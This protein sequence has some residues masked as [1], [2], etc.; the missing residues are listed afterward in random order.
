MWYEAPRH[1]DRISP[2][3]CVLE[4]NGPMRKISEK[5][6]A[7]CIPF[8]HENN[9][10][11]RQLTFSKIVMDRIEPSHIYM[12]EEELQTSGLIVNVFYIAL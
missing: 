5:N 3:N 11:N 1:S 8:T 9:P 2:Q 7:F 4:S 6:A 10:V 12:Q